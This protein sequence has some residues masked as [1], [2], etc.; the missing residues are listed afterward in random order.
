MRDLSERILAVV[1][2]LCEIQQELNTMIL[3]PGSSPHAAAVQTAEPLQ[4]T[5]RMPKIDGVD[6]L[7][8]VVDQVRQFLWFYQQV[9][10][11]ATDHRDGTW[12]SLE[13]IVR[14]PA[15]ANSTKL[16]GLLDRL[17]PSDEIA[18]GQIASKN[19]RKLH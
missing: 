9:T 3:R 5:S 17:K 16:R 18:L 4:N 10:S 12:R 14:D 2:E 19:T 11:S 15:L 7:K 1:D 13:R 6:E 8:L